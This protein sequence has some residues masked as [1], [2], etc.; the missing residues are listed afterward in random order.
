MQDAVVDLAIRI[1]GL[2]A[3]LDLRSLTLTRTR[4]AF[5]Q[6]AFEFAA[7][8][9]SWTAQR[10]AQQGA[11]LQTKWSAMQ[12]ALWAV[13]GFAAP[14]AL[15]VQSVGDM[16]AGLRE[17]EEWA[18]DLETRLRVKNK[19]LVTAAAAIGARHS[20]TT[21]SELNALIT[22]ITQAIRTVLDGDA[23]PIAPVYKR[24]AETALLV[25]AAK[26]IETALGD[27]TRVRKS[28]AGVAGLLKGFNQWKAYPVLK[29]AVAADDTDEQFQLPEDEEPPVSHFG[30]FLST[31]DPAGQRNISGFVVDNW[32][33]QRPS[34]TQD[35]AIAV[36]YDTPQSEAPNCLLLCV[37]PKTGSYAWTDARA[38]QMVRETITWM[39]IRALASHDHLVSPTLRV[40]MN[41]V[42][43]AGSGNK[44][45][46]RIPKA[47]RQ[48]KVGD[49][50]KLDAQFSFVAQATQTFKP[51]KLSAVERS[52]FTR[53]KE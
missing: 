27:W 40:G 49:V 23:L 6:A 38:A 18:V 47:S 10:L 39:K 34:K 21:T 36:N 46:R 48:F 22:Q 33:E 44:Q 11:V 16:L 15:R 24:R 12:D 52:G 8:H 1:T 17:A 29:K 4:T 9:A 31:S 32:T 35:A 37:P 3:E 30:F 19:T 14:E 42:A 28:V 13:S 50:S 26:S 2:S 43:Y 20:L 25:D 5:F 7:Y 45:T 41:Q 51:I 53:I